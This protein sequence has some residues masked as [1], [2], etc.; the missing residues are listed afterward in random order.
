MQ[1]YNTK[2]QTS[3]RLGKK[4]AVAYGIFQGAA[5]LASYIS[6]LLVIISGS[7]IILDGDISKGTLT[8]YLLYTLVVAHAIGAFS[9]K[10]GDLMRASGL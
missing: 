5:E 2:V 7:I 8:S 10:F 3:F 9:H 4:M 1:R 6:V